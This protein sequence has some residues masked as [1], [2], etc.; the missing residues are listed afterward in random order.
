MNAKEV[1]K[2]TGISVRTLHHYDSIGLLCPKRNLENGYRTYSEEDL[3]R[4]QQI[5]FFRACGFPL[6]KIHIM[7]DTPSF[8]RKEAFA[9]QK[10]YLLHE[11]RRIETMLDT[12][13][14]SIQSMEGEITMSI[15]E[16]FNGFDFKTNPYEEEARKLWGD[17]AV[18]QSNTY[19]KSLT[20][21]EVLSITQEMDQLFQKLAVV[22]TEDPASAIA[23][24]AIHEMYTYF[25]NNLGYQYTPQAFAG[26]GQ[27][28]ITDERFTK[29][30][31]QYGI[32][33][34][35]FL[36]QAM[37]IYAESL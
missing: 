28:Y 18:D 16:K 32:G 4:L 35:Q 33:L 21:K 15:T 14:K 31:E 1:A 3:D 30:M 37:E 5:L 22:S 29:A 11:K 9:L 2:L 25:N 34:A 27:L 6:S 19:M 13:N 26:V 10:K 36:A 24:T 8:Q 17:T 7:L 20:E 23:Q 12:I